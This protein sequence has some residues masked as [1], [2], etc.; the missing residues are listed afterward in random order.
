[1]WPNVFPGFVELNPHLHVAELPPPSLEMTRF[2]LAVQS[3]DGIT[4][5]RKKL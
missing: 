4:Q 5:L 1:M 2:T 3:D